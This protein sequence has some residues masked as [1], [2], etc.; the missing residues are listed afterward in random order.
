MG[1]IIDERAKGPKGSGKAK[2]LGRSKETT[3][4]VS[5]RSTPKGVAIL[6]STGSIGRSTLEVI[7]RNPER[8]RVVSLAA[9]N[10]TALLKKQVEEFKPCF[11]STLTKEG[12]S[13]LKDSGA[14]TTG[15]KSGFDIKSGFGVEGAERAASFSGVDIAVSA[16]V[17]AAGL[18]PTLAAIRAGKDIA[19][20]NKEALVI[21]GPLVTTEARKFKV[22]LLPVDS[23][24]S[25]VFQLI[26]GRDKEEIK[27]I[28]L[29]ASG[30]ALRDVPLKDLKDVTPT[31]ALSH[32]TWKMGPRI[33]IDSAT[34]MNKGFEVMEASHLFDMG[35][36]G[37]T[38][39][40]GPMS[41]GEG[42][43]IAVL[44]HPQSIVHSMVEFVDGSIVAELGV[45]DMKG[46]IAYALSYPERL[47]GVRAPLELAGKNLEFIEVD[48]KR[49]PALE[50][51]REALRMGGAA[52]AV[53]NA[54]D[55]VAVD[56]FLSGRIPFTGIHETVSEVLAA[57]S[58]G[59]RNQDVYSLEDIMAADEWAR[60]IALDVALRVGGGSVT[61]TVPKARA[62]AKA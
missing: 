60:R 2:R 27:R 49:Y 57:Y 46:P 62:K 41:S 17:G 50:L 24:H 37:A 47:S 14:L 54:A 34:L 12:L 31:Q 42:E 51:A 8:F 45:S 59:P 10:N 43:K 58:K 13:E 23:E 21:A 4:G 30:G 35:A 48:P 3:V 40:T 29:T 6:G 9:G 16:I 33:T 44:V 39:G 52:G 7:R 22:R 25:A 36:T 5:G 32:P 18:R 19:L 53:L 61:G 55:E 56:A 20:A 1:K 28:I 15:I 11:V 26:E 38:G